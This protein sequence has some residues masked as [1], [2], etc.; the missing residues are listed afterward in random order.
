M[1]YY[2]TNLYS[3]YPYQNTYMPNMQQQTQ[4]SVMPQSI[5]PTPAAAAQ[6]LMGKIVD[7]MEVAKVTDIP[8]GGYGVFPKADM[9]EIYIK[10]WTNSGTTNLITYRPV[11]IEK[12]NSEEESVK[13]ILNR[14]NE[15]ENKIDNILK[16]KE[17]IVTPEEKKE[18][19][20]DT[21]RKELSANVF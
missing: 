10:T 1:N 13:T 18:E 5:P 7:S 8:F 15:I 9:S 14:I 21:Q 16:Q 12:N 20:T 2:P 3:N 6:G 19:K 11:E 17:T 4:Q